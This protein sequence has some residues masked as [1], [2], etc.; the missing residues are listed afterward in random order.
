MTERSTWQECRDLGKM[1]YFTALPTLQVVDLIVARRVSE[2]FETK[3]AGD[4]SL[5]DVSGYKNRGGA[6]DC[7]VACL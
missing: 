4:S 3:R 1:M 5:T 2:G 7:S 6:M